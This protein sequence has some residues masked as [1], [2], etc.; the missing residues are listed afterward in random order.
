MKYVLNKSILGG[1]ETYTTFEWAQKSSVWQ[2]IKAPKTKR[3]AAT[4][5]SC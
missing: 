5:S 1:E 2:F 4:T 3:K